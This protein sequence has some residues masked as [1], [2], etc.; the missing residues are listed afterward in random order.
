MAGDADWSRVLTM[1]DLARGNDI[2]FAA[3]GV[4]DGELLKGVRY[5]ANNRARTSSMVTR[6]KSGTIR[7]IDTTHVL[8]KKPKYAYVK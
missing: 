1:E 7:F 3:T 5:M 2:I 8:D 4:S 6:S